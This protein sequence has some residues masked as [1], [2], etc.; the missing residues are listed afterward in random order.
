MP[1]KPPPPAKP[2]VPAQGSSADAQ[3]LLAKVML[4]LGRKHADPAMR[5]AGER[6]SRLAKQRPGRSD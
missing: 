5:A 3:A 6:L 1:R 4:R 2:P